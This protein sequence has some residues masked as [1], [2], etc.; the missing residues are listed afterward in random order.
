MA[1]CVEPLPLY[2]PRDPRSSGLWRVID[3]HFETFQRV[4]DQRFEAKYGF[5]RPVVERSVTAFLR[6]GDLH[7]GFARVRCPDCRHEMFVTFSCKQRCT[8]PSCHQKRVLLTAAHVAEE[9]CFPVAHRQVVFTIP[10][11]LRLHARFD[12]KLLGKLCS[13]AWTCLQAEIRRILGRHDVAPGMIA[14]IQTHGELLHWHPHIHTLV[15]CGGFTP[16]GDFLDMPQFELDRLRTAWQEAVFALYLAEEKIAPEVIE[17]MRAWPHSGFSV[18]QSVFLPAGDRS[19]IEGLMQYMTRCPFSLSRLVKV[20]KT[21]QV[22]YKAEKDACR[23]FPEPRGDGMASGPKRNFQILDPL[24]FLAK[25]TQHIPPKGAHLIRYYGWY[26]NK[27]RGLRRKAAAEPSA[28]TDASPIPGRSRRPSLRDGA[29]QTWSMLIKRVYEIDPLACPKCGGTMKVI[30]FIEPTQ[31]VVI[32]KILRH[33]GLW[34]PSTPRAP[35]AVDDWGLPPWSVDDFS[36]RPTK[37]SD[38]PLE[39]TYVDIDTFEATF[40]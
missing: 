12:R 7:E 19:G 21:G 37:S 32:E 30:A 9:V 28:Q 5:W 8:C 14:T 40:L 29:R 25:F 15:T 31:G 17:N 2:R 22:I 10:K 35:P 6:C 33:C 1:T 38:E 23:A 3:R 26:S 4:Y 34:R 36:D 18:D 27:N 16:D 24:D 39:W 11:R 20:S 13:C